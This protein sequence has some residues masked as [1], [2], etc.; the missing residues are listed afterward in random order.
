M[1]Q[2]LNLRAHK[3]THEYQLLCVQ[4]YTV[5]IT[6]LHL[7]NHKAKAQRELVT[8]SCLPS[9]AEWTLSINNSVLKGQKE[10]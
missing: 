9:R 3:V 7:T 4:I 10:G 2:I 5:L 1:C 8:S 6:V